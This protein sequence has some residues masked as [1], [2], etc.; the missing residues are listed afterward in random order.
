MTLSLLISFLIFFITSSNK[1]LFTYAKPNAT[2]TDELIHEICRRTRNP[3]LC[4]QTLTPLKGISLLP[5]AVAALGT[6]PMNM[7]QN[8]APATHN[9]IWALHEKIKDSTRNPILVRQK[10]RYYKC[11]VKFCD[12]RRRLTE[13]KMGMRKGNSTSVRYYTSMAVNQAG[14][15]EAE[16]GNPP[17]P[18]AAVAEDFG[19]LGDVCSIIMAICDHN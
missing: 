9:K 6:K 16:F 15:C 18:P 12:V 19:R 17:R 13:A 5:K 8:Q 11:H 1:A 14:S 2:A 3:S 7:A 4:L 10:Q